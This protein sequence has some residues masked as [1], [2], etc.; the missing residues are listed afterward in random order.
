MPPE[1]GFT[2]SQPDPLD[3]LP[4]NESQSQDSNAMALRRV[5]SVML[6]GKGGV[7]LGSDHAVTLLF[8]SVCL[9]CYG[10]HVCVMIM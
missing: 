8:N 6:C 9:P 4:N 7:P 10:T 5:P 1:E 3:T 2:G